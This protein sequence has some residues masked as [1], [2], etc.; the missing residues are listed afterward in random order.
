ARKL[1]ALFEQILLETLCLINVYSRRVSEISQMVF[2]NPKG[3][4]D[5]GLFADHMGADR[6]AIWAAAISGPSAIPVLMLACMLA[7]I[8]K[9]GEVVSIWMEIIEYRQEYI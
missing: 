9:P 6:T 8:W 7:R 1:G 4:K 3:R 2:V 5:D